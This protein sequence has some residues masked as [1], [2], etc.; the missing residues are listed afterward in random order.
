MR[1]SY[2]IFLL[3]I[4]LF[5]IG[6]TVMKSEV[7]K[8]NEGHIKEFFLFVNPGEPSGKTT[9]SVRYY[10]QKTLKERG[11]EVS[12][13]IYN[14][15]DLKVDNNI[16]TYFNESGKEYMMLIA[17]IP[18]DIDTYREMSDERF[19]RIFYTDFTVKP[20]FII[21]IYKKGKPTPIWQSNIN[22]KIRSIDLNGTVFAKN[23]INQLRIDNI[24]P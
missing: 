14:S 3:P 19:A 1:K 6:C 24:I 22:T 23:L 4:L 5:T 20:N 15:N 21:R 11:I 18:G 13:K 17:Q 16:D 10:T 7:S 12:S 2:F 9:Q 8:N